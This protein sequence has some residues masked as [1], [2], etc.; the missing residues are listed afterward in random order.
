MLIKQFFSMPIID[1]SKN[2]KVMEGNHFGLEHNKMDH[3]A[4]NDQEHQINASN[5]PHAITVMVMMKITK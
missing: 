1:N 3:K 5:G 4:Y 2:E